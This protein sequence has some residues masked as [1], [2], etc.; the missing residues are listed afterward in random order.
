[1]RRRTLHVKRSCAC[2]FGAATA[3]P[4][5]VSQRKLALD[6]RVDLCR[7]EN[8][9]QSVDVVHSGRLICRVRLAG[10]DSGDNGR[11]QAMMR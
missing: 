7:R 2:C 11:G 1:V 6:F 5:H 9:R 4:P 10:V 3:P 8:Y